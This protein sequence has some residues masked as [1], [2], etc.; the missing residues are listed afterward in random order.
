MGTLTTRDCSW[1]IRRLKFE[2]SIIQ[3]DFLDRI[4]SK[5]VFFFNGTNTT[6]R[7]VKL[8]C[9]LPVEHLDGRRI[10]DRRHRRRLSSVPD[11]ARVSGTRVFS[12][13]EEK[14]RL[15]DRA[16]SSDF[17]AE[18]NVGSVFFQIYK[19]FVNYRVRPRKWDTIIQ[20][21]HPFLGNLPHPLD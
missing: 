12:C 18:K 4:W 10:V 9:V 19:N 3:A 17:P 21:F 13:S 2:R 1:P 14:Q 11:L 7:V 5:N 16:L 20:F 15:K 6:R 8:K